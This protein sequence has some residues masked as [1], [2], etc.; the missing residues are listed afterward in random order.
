MI[1][2]FQNL[3]NLLYDRNWSKFFKFLK[4]LK[5]VEIQQKVEAGQVRQTYAMLEDCQNFKKISLFETGRNLKNF[6]NGWNSTKIFKWSIV[7]EIQHISLWLKFEQTYEMIKTNR[8]KTQ[9]LELVEIWE[10]S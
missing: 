1:K 2:T 4:W 9:F 6:L 10:T 8:F 3:I 7:I 5:M